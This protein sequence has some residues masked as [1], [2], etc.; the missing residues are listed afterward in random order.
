MAERKAKE[1]SGY[2]ELERQARIRHLADLVLGRTET[3]RN[4]PEIYREELE[5]D[6]EA[7]IE[8]EAIALYRMTTGKKKIPP[9][10]IPQE[11]KNRALMEVLKRWQKTLKEV[12]ETT[13]KVAVPPEA[14]YMV[15]AP[16]V[17]PRDGSV[18]RK[19]IGELWQ[20]PTCF[21]VMRVPGAE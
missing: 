12:K 17:C 19:L 5:K 16:P 2:A 4:P 7:I 6:I 3:K 9:E 15:G 14:K 8:Q 13:E 21:R 10:G 20:C 18:M 11:Y 1:V